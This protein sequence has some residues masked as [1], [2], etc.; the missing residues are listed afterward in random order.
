MINKVVPFVFA[1]MFVLLLLN[2][3]EVNNTTINNYYG[4]GSNDCC[5]GNSPNIELEIIIPTSE[6]V[7]CEVEEGLISVETLV[8]VNSNATPTKTKTKTKTPNPT[9]VVSTETPIPTIVVPTETPIPTK[10]P[11]CDNGGGNG[12]EGCSRSDNGNDDEGGYVVLD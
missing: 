9:I 1:V 7:V 12:S 11:H 3:I 8:T 6:L 4:D 5:C 10:K 2:E